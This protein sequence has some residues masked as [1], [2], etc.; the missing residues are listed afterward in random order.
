MGGSLALDSPPG[1]GTRVRAE[2]PYGPMR[3]ALGAR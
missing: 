1:A 2:I 3:S